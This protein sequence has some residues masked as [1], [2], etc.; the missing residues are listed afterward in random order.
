M[1]L[2]R[3]SRWVDALM[4]KEKASGI[5][6]LLSVGRYTH[7]PN[8]ETNGIKAPISG[9]KYQWTLNAPVDMMVSMM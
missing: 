1:A 3:P 7:V 2:K 4:P 6:T 5:E 9:S 8:E